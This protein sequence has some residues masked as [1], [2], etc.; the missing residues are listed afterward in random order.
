MEQLEEF[1]PEAEENRRIT[2]Y[3]LAKNAQ[4]KNEA[5]Q[6]KKDR[7]SYFE[8]LYEDIRY[9]SVRIDPFRE[10]SGNPAVD[11]Q[12]MEIIDAKIAYDKRIMKL[13]ER[14]ARWR[15]FL[16]K[17]N[18][19]ESDLLRRYFENGD[20]IS[21]ETIR[22][23][24]FKAGRILESSEEA[25]GKAMDQ[26][27]MEEYREYQKQ[28]PERFKIFS[29]QLPLQNDESKQQYLINGQFVYMSPEEYED[30]LEQSVSV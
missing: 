18:K 9:Y 16:H 6:M 2:M 17:F 25:R 28:F 12:A 1:I 13:N 22:R 19:Q 3:E 10:G 5:N 4:A 8:S 26:E 7:A 11:Y 15:G 30:H 29:T 23:L 21:Y 14:Y 20:P 24:L 27:T